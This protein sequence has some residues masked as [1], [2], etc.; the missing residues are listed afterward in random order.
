MCSKSNDC[1]DGITHLIFRA[2]R[3]PGD[4]MPAPS[5]EFGIEKIG[6]VAWAVLYT[7]LCLAVLHTLG[8]AACTIVCDTFNINITQDCAEFQVKQQ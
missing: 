4:H 6:I 8:C 2:D 5:L 1:C 7:L 3:Y